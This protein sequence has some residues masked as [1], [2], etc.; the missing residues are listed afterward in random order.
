MEAGLAGSGLSPAWQRKDARTTVPSAQWVWA[1][2]GCTW[3]TACVV[4]AVQSMLTWPLHGG[5]C[6]STACA[7]RALQA[8]IKL[9]AGCWRCWS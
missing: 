8:S 4:D 2:K 5:P 6:V 3:L 9:T 7:W 1:F